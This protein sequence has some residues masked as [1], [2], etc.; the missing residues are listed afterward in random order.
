MACGWCP[1]DVSG[2]DAGHSDVARLASRDPTGFDSPPLHTLY[3]DRPAL[4]AI[5]RRDVT[6]D[7]PVR[8]DVKAKLRSSIRR[9]LVKYDYPPDK[10]QGAI[11]LVIQQMESMAP[12]LAGG[13]GRASGAP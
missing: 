8:D 11:R 2:R 6:T 9:L 10:Q 3:L 12:R 7:W 1:W 4:V 13:Q 5:M